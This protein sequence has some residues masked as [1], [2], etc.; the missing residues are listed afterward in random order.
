MNTCV[1]VFPAYQAHYTMEK[2]R[3]MYDGVSR[4]VSVVTCGNMNP[5][6]PFLNNK[7][8]GL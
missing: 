4:F 6:R 2:E 1:H 3:F 8:H 7:L 5:L